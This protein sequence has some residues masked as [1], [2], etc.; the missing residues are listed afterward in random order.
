MATFPCRFSAALLA[1][2]LREQQALDFQTLRIRLP[3]LC[4][5]SKSSSQYLKEE[6]R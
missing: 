4:L 1:D 2:R 3:R 5:F 6:F